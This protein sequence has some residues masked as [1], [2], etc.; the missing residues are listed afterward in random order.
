MKQAG[1]YYWYHNDHLGTPQKL[2]TTSGAVVWSAKYTSFGKAI[3]DPS[4]AIVNALRLSG[5][6]FDVETGIHWNWFRYFDPN[7]GRYLKNDPIGFFGGDVNL[8]AYVSN[9]PVNLIDPL[10]LNPNS[11]KCQRLLQRIKNIQNKIDERLGELKEDPQGLPERCPG[12]TQKPSL[13]RYGHREILIKKDKANLARLKA[14]YLAECSNT[15]PNGTP[16]GNESFF[17]RKFWED[18]TGLTGAALITYIIISE[19][20]RLFPPRNLVP[21]P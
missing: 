6:Y 16:V 13:S 12:D 15:P 1:Q 5:Q 19:G 9:N 7:L 2:T 17:D 14:K 8:Y 20:S 10:G 3:V 18:V 4:S 21:I 11:Q